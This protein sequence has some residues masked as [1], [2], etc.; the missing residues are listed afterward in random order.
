MILSF[1]LFLEFSGIAFFVETGARFIG[2]FWPSTQPSS[3]K[4]G[5]EKEEKWPQK[6]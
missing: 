5:Q 4:L 1:E 3:A 6:V 2:L